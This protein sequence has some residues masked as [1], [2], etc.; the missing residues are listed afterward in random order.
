MAEV[1]NP[2]GADAEMDRG[3]T[4]LQL[5]A[6][7]YDGNQIGERF[8]IAPERAEELIALYVQRVLRG[9]APPAPSPD[10]L[11]N[12]FDGWCMKHGCYHPQ[13]G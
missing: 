13:R 1:E 4:L 7:G 5:V 8:D 11:I 2:Y 12:G 9:N 3:N 10:C 6:E